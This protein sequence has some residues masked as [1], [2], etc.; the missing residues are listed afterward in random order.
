MSRFQPD[1]IVWSFLECVS[2]F[3]WKKLSNHDGGF[4]WENVPPTWEPRR[5]NYHMRG[6]STTYT[7]F[8]ATADAEIW[9]V[10]MSEIVFAISTAAKWDVAFT[11]IDGDSFR[12]R[13]LELLRKIRT[14]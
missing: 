2:L 14:S 3:Y 8:R 11:T 6:K 5:I 4:A 9:L 7:F 12:R 10:S 13:E 1:S